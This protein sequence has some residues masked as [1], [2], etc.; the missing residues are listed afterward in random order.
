M[1]NLLVVSVLGISVV[2]KHIM[3]QWYSHRGW[4]LCVSYRR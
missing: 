4:R 3:F 1:M 2:H